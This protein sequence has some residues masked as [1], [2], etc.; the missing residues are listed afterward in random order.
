MQGFDL[1]RCHMDRTAARAE[2]RETHDIRGGQSGQAT[3]LDTSFDSRSSP[4]TNSAPH[5]LS[6]GRDRPKNEDEPQHSGFPIGPPHWYW[7]SG[8]ALIYGKLTGSEAF[9]SL[10]PWMT[11]AELNA[12]RWWSKAETSAKPA[13]QAKS[14]SACVL[15]AS[16]R[17][18]QV[19]RASSSESDGHGRLAGPITKLHGV[20]KCP[21]PR[22]T[23]R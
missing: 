8:R 9:A 21:Q 10:W 7:L 23:S 20:S 3:S 6:H 1:E 19:D 22:S 15:S 16:Y 17:V 5:Q 4:L 18:F 13:H 2:S 14:T 11:Q 12:G